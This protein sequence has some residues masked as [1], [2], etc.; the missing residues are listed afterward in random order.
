MN[1]K[2]DPARVGPPAD[3]TG[4]YVRAQDERGTWRSADVAQLTRES[5]LEWLRGGGGDNPLAERVVC[6]LLGHAAPGD[7]R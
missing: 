6:A 2:I 4:I 7:E 3:T 5:L 1:L